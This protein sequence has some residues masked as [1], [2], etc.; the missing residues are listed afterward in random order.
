LPTT[1]GVVGGA[2]LPLDLRVDPRTSAAR[3]ADWLASQGVHFEW[4]S[5]VRTVELH[6]VHTSTATI[7]ADA[8]VVAVGH[9][10]DEMFPGLAQSAGIGRCRLSMLAVAN[11]LPHAVEP[12]VMSGFSMLR[13]PA[14]EVCPSLPKL[15]SSLQAS[16][17]DAIAAELNLMATQ[18]PDGDLIIGD[19]HDYGTNDDPFRAEER[20]QL[21]LREAAALLGVDHLGVRQRWQ[22]VYAS[23]PQP[24]LLA[25]PQPGVTL[26]AVTTGIGMTTAFGFA[27][28][29]LT[30]ALGSA[31]ERIES[32]AS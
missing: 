24:Y 1:A 12:A 4:A 11:P 30:A 20:D 6:A 9:D 21:V 19:T 32:S 2:F 8:V 18:L 7:A 14:Y 16:A 15:R 28:D 26:A 5:S 22:G 29:V 25:T 13:Y 31:G 10:V 17:P 3:I 23:A 27:A